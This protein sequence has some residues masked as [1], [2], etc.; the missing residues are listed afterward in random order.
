[1]LLFI[2][3][4]NL[5]FD[6]KTE[7]ITVKPDFSLSKDYLANHFNYSLNQFIEDNNAIQALLYVCILVGF[8]LFLKNSWIY[9]IN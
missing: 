5:L 4:L 8:L 7:K 9:L 3:L 2:P 1:M 6:Q